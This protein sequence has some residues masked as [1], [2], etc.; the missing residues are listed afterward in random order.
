MKRLILMGEIGAGKSTL[1]RNALGDNAARAGGFVT[2]RITE[3]GAVQ[4][5]D[6]APAAALWDPALPAQRFLDFSCGQ[7][8]DD[9]VFAVPGASLLA[10]ALDAPYAV[11]DEF[12]GLELL[13]PEFYDGLV[14]LL[15]SDIPTIGVLKTPASVRALAE[16]IPLGE[17][18]ARKADSLRRLL[19]ADP[20]TMIL[21]ISGWDD[22]NAARTVQIWVET[23]VRR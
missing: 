16:R 17:E 10:H 11:A 22:P 5:F 19:E 21:P 20:E 15:T 8:R 1:I 23:Y 4:G 3:K 6:L 18:Y 2:R 7:Q 14:K 13:V 12:G 9:S